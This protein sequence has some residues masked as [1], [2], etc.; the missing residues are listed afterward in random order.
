MAM[1]TRPWLVDAIVSRPSASPTYDI[2]LSSGRVLDPASGL[3]G[4]RHV[5]ITGR[6][7]AAVSAQA[8]RGRIELDATGLIVAPG[9]IDLHSHG[10]T[11]E[12]YRYKAMDG[13]TTALE[14][15]VGVSPVREWYAAR[16]GRSL[17]NFGASSGHVPARMAVMKATGGC[18]AR[19]EGE[20]RPAP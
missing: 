11:P 1:R 15:E 13:V 9:F 12:N 5:G 16:E 17:I 10:Q 20:S 7:I 19:R 2:V 3:D 6:K 18:I 8:L 4:I 14:L